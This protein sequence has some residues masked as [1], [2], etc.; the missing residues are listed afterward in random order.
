[1][2]GI[3]NIAYVVIGIGWFLWNMYRK[4][5]AGKASS[6]PSS[7]R[8][9]PVDSEPTG[10]ASRSLED[11]I[12]EQFGEKETLEPVV[13][14]TQQYDNQDK[15]LNTDL[16]HSHLSD[17]YEMS[18]SEMKSHRVERQVRKLEEEIEEESILNQNMPNGFDLRQ[19]I[20]MNAVL[21]RPYS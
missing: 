11:M 12:L 5:Q 21:E 2:D 18:K 20:I 1:M 17:D 3:E 14:H 13:S 16:T 7:R 9:A 8:S 19:A 15:F 10:K 4:Q 6:Q